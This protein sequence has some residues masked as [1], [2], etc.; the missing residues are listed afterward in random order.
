M[1]IFRYTFAAGTDTDGNVVIQIPC[2]TLKM[3]NS[4]NRTDAP[5]ESPKAVT[6]I[7]MPEA[8]WDRLK[9]QLDDIKNFVADNKS[10]KDDDVWLTINEAAKVLKV[11]RKTLQIYRNRHYVPFSQFGR[12]ICFKKSDIERFMNGNV[13]E[14]DGGDIDFNVED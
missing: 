9:Q 11:S 5:A 14:A 8:E 4:N 10:K 13:I 3:A 6:M 2:F 12:K 1:A 7:L